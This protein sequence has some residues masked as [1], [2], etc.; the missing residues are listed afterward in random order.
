MDS[1]Y[2]KDLIYYWLQIKYDGYVQIIAIWKK[3]DMDF[4]GRKRN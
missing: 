2:D 4:D 1:G 3:G